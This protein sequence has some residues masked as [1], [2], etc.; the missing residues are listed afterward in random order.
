MK[1]RASTCIVFF[2]LFFIPCLF[3]SYKIDSIK[4]TNLYFSDTLK[5]TVNKINKQFKNNYDDYDVC[6]YNKIP[7]ILIDRDK[8][9]KN[10]KESGYIVGIENTCDDTCVCIIDLQLRI[11]KNFI[12]SH[13]KVVHKYG[14]VYPFFISSINSVFLKHYVNKILEGIDASKIK[15]FG[16]SVCPGISQNMDTA[17]NYIGDFKK[18]HK[19]IKASSI[20]H[21]YA[22]VLSPLFFSFY[23]DKNTFT[24]N[25]EYKNESTQKD[26]H[27][28]H[29]NMNLFDTIKKDKIQMDK[30]NSLLKVLNNNDVTKKKLKMI[31][32]DDFLNYGSYVLKKK[33]IDDNNIQLDETKNNINQIKENTNM[34]KIPLNY[35][36]NGYICVLVSGGSTQV[37]R[38]QKDK[39][40]DI[41][42]CKI[43][44]T[45]DISVGDII[46]KVA[47]LLNLPVGLGGGPF[48]ERES[49]KYIKT[50]ND[51]KINEDISFD[52]FEPFPV[53]FA[54]NN[55]INF[56]FSGIFNHLSKIIKELKKEKNFENEKSKYAYYCQKYIF[57]H[58]LNQ[59]NKIMYFSELHFNI[60]N[61][62]IVGGVGCN[63][64]LFESLKKLA[65]NRNKIENQ[66]KEYIKLKK[67]LKKK[68]K[69]IENNNFLTKKNPP[70][71][72][73]INEIE[74][75]SSF[76]WNFYLK[77]LL[78][79]KTSNDILL[80]LKAFDFNSFTKLK[81]KGSFLLQDQFLT[82]SITQP[83]NVYRTP[84]NLS[85]DNAAM[86]CFNTLLNMH[87]KI[88]IHEDIS[89][90]KIKST[91]KTQLQN[92]FLL[93]SDIIVFDVFLDYFDHNVA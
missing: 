93:L 10:N 68:I 45:V 57:K 39:Q 85:R 25:Y 27:T 6:K 36:Q 80:A 72:N 63:K 1:L 48:L 84:I 46:D 51:Q 5:G 19:H 42:V 38:V 92:N 35:I 61:L 90:I 64:F 66:L 37:Y 91:I 47:R 71:N 44:Q 82:S 4:I 9:K 29:I 54:P 77:N 87:N 3:N 62:F 17:R 18:R 70:T 30:I 31:T 22:H 76:A 69:K 26:D 28:D 56:S 33:K 7:K 50:L 15:C 21:V 88:N 65:L 55:K 86:I 78:K 23:N 20:N 34:E 73:M 32:A 58:L 11:I 59:L 14:G 12:I 89:E 81:E 2:L 49:E 79:K 13:F 24:N 43:S 8:I 60:K 75:S 53:P 40:N 52:L 41:N 67:R 83:W 16:F 74:L